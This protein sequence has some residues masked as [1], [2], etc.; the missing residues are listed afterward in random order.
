MDTV[1]TPSEQPAEQ[2]DTEPTVSTMD[3]PVETIV[4]NT[5]SVTVQIEPD[6]ESTSSDTTVITQENWDDDPTP[7]MNGEIDTNVTN[8]KS[9]DYP[10]PNQLIIP[11]LDHD[12]LPDAHGTL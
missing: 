6:D 1:P 3:T 5:D 10:F 2:P 7:A 8:V 11:D 4:P 12:L 9:T